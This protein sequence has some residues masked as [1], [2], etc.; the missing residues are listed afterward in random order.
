MVTL[1]AATELLDALL[2]DEEELLATPEE[3]E[4]LELVA[5]LELLDDAMELLATL[6]ELALLELVAPLGVEV[7]AAPP[8]LL[9]PQAVSAKIAAPAATIRLNL[10]EYIIGMVPVFSPCS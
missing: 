10:E 5:P 1:F 3:L 2:D 8:E 6:E 9:P 7:G 4:L